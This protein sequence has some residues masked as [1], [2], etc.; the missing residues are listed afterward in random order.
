MN[1]SPPKIRNWQLATDLWQ[2]YFA[3][4][5]CAA[6]RAANSF[7]R[8]AVGRP[9][10]HSSGHHLSA[11]RRLRSFLVRAGSADWWRCCGRVPRA[12]SKLPAPFACAPPSPWQGFLLGYVCGILWYAGTCYWIYDT[13]R[14]Y[15]GLSAPEALLALFLFSC[16]LG[17]YHGFFG[18]L[19]SLAR[20]RRPR[21]PPPAGCRSVPLGRGGTGAHPHHGLSLEPARDIARLT[22]S[23]SAASPARPASTASRLKLLW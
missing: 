20:R 7:E 6:N 13:M 19:V 23:R 12:N 8:V 17:L 18:L 11:S 15:G 5:L 16:Y 22:T 14:Q 3:I 9:L 2:L 1:A 21:L 4:L 10:G